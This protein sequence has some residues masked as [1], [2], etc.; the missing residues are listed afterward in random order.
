MGYATQEGQVVGIF[1]RNRLFYPDSM[2]DYSDNERNIKHE[3]DYSGTVFS[4]GRY[5]Y[6]TGHKD[7]QED[8]AGAPACKQPRIGAS[9]DVHDGDKDCP[10]IIDE[11]KWDSE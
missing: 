5:V 6:P 8:E 11:S 7:A 1:D 2:L 9:G 10:L 4:G 3:P